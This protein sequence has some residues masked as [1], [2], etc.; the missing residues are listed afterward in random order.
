LSPSPPRGFWEDVLR[1]DREERFELEWPKGRVGGRRSSENGLAADVGFGICRR[2]LEVKSDGALGLWFR[3]GL[4]ELKEGE[5]EDW[6]NVESRLL[7][8]VSKYVLA[9]DKND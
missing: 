3:L 4:C 8:R 6:E 7:L 9:R 5:S 1:L 2:L